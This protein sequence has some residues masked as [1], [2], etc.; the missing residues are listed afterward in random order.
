M[1]IF[2]RK[3]DKKGTFKM[4]PGIINKMILVLILLV[5]LFKVGAELIPEAQS[6]GNELCESGIPFASLFNA[7]GI[8]FIVLAAALLLVV[9]NAFLKRGRR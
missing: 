3:L 8:V 4:D 5:L 1:N 2:S 9:V 6:A 7:D